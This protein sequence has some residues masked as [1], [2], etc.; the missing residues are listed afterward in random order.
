MIYLDTTALTKL[1]AAD[2]QTPALIEYLRT[3]AGGWFTCALTRLDLIR[4]S[5]A[6]HPD[7]EARARTVLASC[8]IVAVTDRL[9]DAAAILRPSPSATVNALHVAAAASAGARLHS[10]LTYDADLA[11]DAGAHHITVRSPGGGPC[12]EP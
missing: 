10:L 2:P 12:S 3:A 8:D 5:A 6:I 4:A 9:L 11:A 7:A 1:V